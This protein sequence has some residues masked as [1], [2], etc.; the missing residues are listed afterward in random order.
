MRVD[1]WGVMRRCFLEC[2]VGMN[3]FFIGLIKLY[4]K[5]GESGENHQFYTKFSYRLYINELMVD[6]LHID[7]Y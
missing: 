1:K 6:L 7:H 2:K 3:N 5:V 4:S